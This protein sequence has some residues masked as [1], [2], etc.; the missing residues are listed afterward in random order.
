M[1][2]RKQYGFATWGLLERIR[3]NC[4]CKAN[5]EGSTAHDIPLAKLQSDRFGSFGVGTFGLW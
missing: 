5:A 2:G 3:D 1:D 4:K